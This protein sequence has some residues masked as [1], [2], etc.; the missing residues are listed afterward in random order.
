MIRPPQRPSPSYDIAVVRYN[1]KGTV[2]AGVGKDGVVFTD[3]EHDYEENPGPSGVALQSDGKIVV[4]ATAFGSNGQD[5][6]VLL[7]LG[8][9]PVQYRSGGERSIIN[10]TIR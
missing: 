6:V 3:L 4:G 8:R 1:A 7:Y 2:D 9:R 10:G 5:F